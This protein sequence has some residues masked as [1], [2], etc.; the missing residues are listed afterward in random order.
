MWR[1][2]LLASRYVQASGSLAPREKLLP[3]PPPSALFPCGCVTD[4]PNQ[5]DQQLLRFVHR[6]SPL[7]PRSAHPALAASGKIQIRAP[8]ILHPWRPFVTELQLLLNAR[9]LRFNLRL[10][11]AKAR[12]YSSRASTD[13]CYYLYRRSS[14][15]APVKTQ[16]QVS[17]YPLF[18][19]LSRMLGPSANRVLVLRAYWTDHAAAPVG[20]R[21]RISFTA[22]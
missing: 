4:Q 19:F 3:M 22:F 6:P 20:G 14:G 13:A 8:Q 7:A 16:R 2:A 18:S 11:R 9:S 12:K 5:C 10:A 21:Q 17:R 15:D 1:A